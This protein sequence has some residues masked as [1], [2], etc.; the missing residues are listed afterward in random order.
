[1][2]GPM[3]VVRVS[4]ISRSAM[5]TV[6]AAMLC[7]LL[8]TAEAEP[9]TL[10]VHTF[11]SPKAL[12]VRSFIVP[13]AREL[14]E[15]SGGRVKVQVFPSMQLGGKASDLY[16]Q[17]RDGV[18]DI[19]WT[20]QGYSPGRFSL[21]EVFELPFVCAGAEATSLAMMEFY[22]KWMQDEYA[23]TH[24]L[25]FHAT[26]PAHIHTT[27]RPVRTL[28]DL[29]GLKTRVP[30]QASA[31]TVEALAPFRSACRFRMS[32]RRSREASWAVYGWPGSSCG[33]S[34]C[35]K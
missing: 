3:T 32:M 25:V 17:A 24:P 2:R 4:A 28:E 21:T 11:N 33:P 5:C 7:A 18:V 10:R 6:A 22:R 27:D 30:S 1:M 9:I 34:G 16:G 20:S 35:M 14:E 15:R 13:W 23:D 26:A 31:A 8:N 12:A 29:A 19:V